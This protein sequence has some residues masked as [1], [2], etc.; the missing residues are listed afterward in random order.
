MVHVEKSINVLYSAC[1]RSSR[2]HS[3]SFTN[4]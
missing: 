1:C 3:I 2:K 4:W